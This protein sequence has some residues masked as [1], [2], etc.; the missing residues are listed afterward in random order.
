MLRRNAGM[1]AL[2]ALFCLFLSLFSTRSS[3]EEGL[4]PETPLIRDSE[5]LEKA[6]LRHESARAAGLCPWLTRNGPT[7]DQED[8]LRTTRA[9]RPLE[10][11]RGPQTGFKKAFLGE[12]RELI[13]RADTAIQTA[14]IALPELEKSAN[15]ENLTVE[16]LADGSLLSTWVGG[17]WSKDNDVDFW[18]CRI[19]DAC[20]CVFGG[21]LSLC[22][23]S[24][25]QREQYKPT[26]WLPLTGLK[27]AGFVWDHVVEEVLD[28]KPTGAVVGTSF[29]W[30][31]PEARA[32]GPLLL[33]SFYVYSYRERGEGWDEWRRAALQNLRSLDANGDGD[34]TLTE[35]LACGRDHVNAA[36][37]AGESRCTFVNTQ[38][39]LAGL[40]PVLERVEKHAA[41]GGYMLQVTSRETALTN[42]MVFRYT[43]AKDEAECTRL[44]NAAMEEVDATQCRL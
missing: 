5:T 41:F 31:T 11:I 44:F 37:M 26:F 13:Q 36:W 39:Y 9:N 24:E 29:P 16:C 35:V 43:E 28:S 18:A 38:T 4:G 10:F 2:A 33:E 30:A 7:K 25:G 14:N 21:Q 23:R 17:D 22:F 34:I 8:L 20:A 40:L 15:F 19:R 42:K 27:N 12:A 1:A 3:Q 6:L 32:S